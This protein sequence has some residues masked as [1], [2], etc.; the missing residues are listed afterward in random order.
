MRFRSITLPLIATALLLIL[1][2]GALAQA[3]RGQNDSKPADADD[4]R[5]RLQGLDKE[6]DSVLSEVNDLHGKVDRAERFEAT[7]ID[8]LET[9]V[10]E[11]QTR[12]ENALQSTAGARTGGS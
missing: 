4:P 8:S 11:L 12:V 6:T 3:G 7:K 2:G 10:T 1:C 5:V 9:S